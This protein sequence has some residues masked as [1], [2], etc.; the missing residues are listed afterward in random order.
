MIGSSECK[1]DI[2]ELLPSK[3][4]SSRGHAMAV[5]LVFR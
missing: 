3:I 4:L 2:K 1:N 5:E